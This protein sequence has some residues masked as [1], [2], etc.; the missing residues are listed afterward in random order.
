M[1]LEM[2]GA[3]IPEVP[4]DI[5]GYEVLAKRREKQLVFLHLYGQGK[6]DVKAAC[7]AAGIVPYTHLSWLNTHPMYARAFEKVRLWLGAKL[8]GRIYDRAYDGVDKAIYYKGVKVDVVKEFDHARELS[9]MKVMDP[10][11]WGDVKSK[12][13]GELETK[14]HELCEKAGLKWDGKAESLG[15]LS[16]G[17]GSVEREGAGAAPSLP[18][19]VGEQAKPEGGVGKPSDSSGP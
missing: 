6:G 18:E 1:S 13:D 12:S 3:L 7:E 5:H 14:I 11:R 9:V 17:N 19:G 8:E 16:N 15:E 2:E 10:A 4:K